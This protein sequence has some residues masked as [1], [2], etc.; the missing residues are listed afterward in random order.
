MLVAIS[1]RNYAQPGSMLDS[2]MRTVKGAGVTN[3]IVVALD[4]DTKKHAEDNG[5]TSVIMNVKVMCFVGLIFRDIWPYRQEQ[6]LNKKQACI[7][8][9]KC[10]VPFC[11]CL[12]TLGQTSCLLH[13]T[14]HS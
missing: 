3:A 4:E 14:L 5:F 1:N 9:R 6:H 12:L 11:Y 13:K 2:W 8:S 10:L 7:C